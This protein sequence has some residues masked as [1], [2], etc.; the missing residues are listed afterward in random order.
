MDDFLTTSDAAS[1]VGL[2]QNRLWHLARSGK[3]DFVPRVVAGRAL[4]LRSDLERLA[5]RL[6][7]EAKAAA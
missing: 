4:W 2:S 3:C 1:L 5:K 6:K 7:A